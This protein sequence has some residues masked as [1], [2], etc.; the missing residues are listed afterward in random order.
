[1]PTIPVAHCQINTDNVTFIGN[2]LKKEKFLQENSSL[3]FIKSNSDYN[4][5]IDL[6]QSFQC[7]SIIC[8]CSTIAISLPR[9]LSFLKSNYSCPISLIVFIQSSDLIDWN[10]LMCLVNTYNLSLNIVN[11]ENEFSKKLGDIINNLVNQNIDKKIISINKNKNDSI[12]DI[13]VKL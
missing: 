11:N 3:T 13:Q 2:L 10:P 8:C 9:L 12:T 4:I 7:P 1:M 6:S 5:Q